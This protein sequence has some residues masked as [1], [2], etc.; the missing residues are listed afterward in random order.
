VAFSPDG[1]TL[2]SASSDET[3]RLWEVATGQPIGAP[4]AGHTDWVRSVAFSPD[5]QTLASASDDDTIRLWEVATGQPIGAPLAGHT[6]WVNS[7]AFSPDGQ[8]LASGS[9]DGTVRL[10]AVLS[11]TE[12]AAIR[13]AR[14]AATSEVQEAIL[15]QWAVV[16]GPQGA[17]ER[18]PGMPDYDYGF[19][20]DGTLESMRIQTRFGEEV[21]TEY[22][23]DNSGSY[24]FIDNQR[25]QLYVEDE[26]VEVQ[27]TVDGD[28]M[29]WIME[30]EVVQLER[31]KDEFPFQQLHRGLD[32]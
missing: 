2:A 23:I 7:V 32:Q 3:I 26:L 6:D 8:T 9:L 15:G 22:T 13:E 5:G 27:I 19:L 12:V 14:V 28:Q 29:T 17:I 20:A 1:Q 25:L 21:T 10:W 30:G 4:L 24:E 31:A 11:E 18:E 16:R